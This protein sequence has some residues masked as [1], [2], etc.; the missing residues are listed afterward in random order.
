MSSTTDA[1][2]PTSSTTDSDDDDGGTAYEDSSIDEEESYY[3]EESNTLCMVKPT[4]K[5]KRSNSRKN[6]SRC[7]SDNLNVRHNQDNQRDFE[8][9]A[10]VQMVTFLTKKTMTENLVSKSYNKQHH[11]YKTKQ[12]IGG[13]YIKLEA[14]F[15]EQL[16]QSSKCKNLVTGKIRIKSN[17][18]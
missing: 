3:S 17:K 6:N 9:R 13:T 15:R 14:E 5:A 11:G 18:Y 7:W 2:S 12:P 10:A 4:R 16:T 1:S 8:E